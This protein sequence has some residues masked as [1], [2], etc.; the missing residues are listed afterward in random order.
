MHDIVC[1]IRLNV[2][3]QHE[4]EGS[5]RL[6]SLHFSFLKSLSGKIKKINE[7]QKSDSLQ[8]GNEFE[9]FFCSPFIRCAYCELLRS[10]LH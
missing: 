6:S 4:Q 10:S 1:A 2:S 8:I 7:E 5:K 3:V 9:H